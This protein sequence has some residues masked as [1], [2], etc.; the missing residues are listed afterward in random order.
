MSSFTTRGFARW[1]AVVVL[2]A[3]LLLVTACGSSGTTSGSASSLA[4]SS[5]SAAPSASAT[6]AANAEVCQDVAALRASLSKLT[7]V[8]VSRGAAST[9]AANARDV[10]AKL[11][12]LADSVGTLWNSQ[13]GALTSALSKLQ[14]AVT[15]LGNGGSLSSVGSALA[16]VRT[17]AQDLL[18]AAGTRCPSSSPSP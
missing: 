15:G 8:T 18:T 14:D 3:G 17:A 7:Q 2:V 1:R 4:S 6:A 12:T 9:R 5:T 10:Q 11:T 16:S 13:I